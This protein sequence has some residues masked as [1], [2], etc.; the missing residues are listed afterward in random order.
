M[1]GRP[2]QSR[3]M[4]QRP[5]APPLPLRRPAL[6]QRTQA[7]G[8][9]D[10]DRSLTAP[11]WRVAPQTVRTLLLEAAPPQRDRAGREREPL[12]DG[13]HRHPLCDQQHDAGTRDDAL[14]RC[15]RSNPRREKLA[16]GLAHAYTCSGR[17]CY[18]RDAPSCPVSHPRLAPRVRGRVAA[19]FVAAGW[20]HG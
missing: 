2:A 1:N 16:L 6:Q 9:V 17:W 14:R 11:A 20:V 8:G 5:D 10:A 3:C 15:P 18:F 4:R 7:R 13:A 12:R 19:T